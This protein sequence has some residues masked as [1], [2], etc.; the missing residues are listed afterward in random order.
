MAPL[1]NG[2]HFLPSLDKGGLEELRFPVRKFAYGGG[3]RGAQ[4]VGGET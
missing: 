4:G 2:Q 1:I 3:K